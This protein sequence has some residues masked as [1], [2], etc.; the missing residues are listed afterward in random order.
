MSQIVYL[1]NKPKTEEEVQYV[2]SYKVYCKSHYTQ[3][4]QDGTFM[5]SLDSSRP[6]QHS[7]TSFVNEVKTNKRF[8]KLWDKTLNV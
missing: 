5:E 8:A 4:K 1:S 3:G 2:D 6:I 7:L